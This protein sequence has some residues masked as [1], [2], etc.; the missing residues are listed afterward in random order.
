M[1]EIRGGS[2]NR[3]IFGMLEIFKKNQK[4]FMFFNNYRVLQ[5]HVMY[6]D[7]LIDEIVPPSL[8]ASEKL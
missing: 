5:K 3:E 4:L 8:E 7:G 2:G 1:P 6:H